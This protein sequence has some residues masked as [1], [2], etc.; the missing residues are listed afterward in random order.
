MMGEAKKLPGMENCQANYNIS[1]PPIFIDAWGKMNKIA[2]D[3]IWIVGAVSVSVL[4]FDWQ[5][6]EMKRDQFCD[7]IHIEC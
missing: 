2:F 1:S 3:V 6:I 5:L 7:I 4:D